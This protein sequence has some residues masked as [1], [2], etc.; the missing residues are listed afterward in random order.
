MEGEED[1]PMEQTRTTRTD[2]ARRV[3]DLLTQPADS[4]AA[5]IVA[6]TAQQLAADSE[7]RLVNH[8]LTP[9]G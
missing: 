8:L 5:S 1:H 9:S 4:A 3:L 7:R 6:A 2:H